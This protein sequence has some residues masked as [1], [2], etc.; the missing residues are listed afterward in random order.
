M[1]GPEKLLILCWKKEKKKKISF[2]FSITK[3][4]S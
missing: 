3:S 2:S 1:E 4:V